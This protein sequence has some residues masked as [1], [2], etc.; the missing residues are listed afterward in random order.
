M[1]LSISIST[2]L[3]AS[4]NG[5]KLSNPQMYYNSCHSH[6]LKQMIFFCNQK[7]EIKDI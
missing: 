5:Q 7:F 4:L 3:I 2:M 6:K 1:Y